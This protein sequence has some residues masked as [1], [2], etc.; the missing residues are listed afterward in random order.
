MDSITQAALGAAVGEAILGKKLGNKGA[1]IGA[2]IATIPDLDILLFPFFNSLQRISL[3]RGY[4]HSIIFCLL[5]AFFLAFLLKQIDWK[6]KVSYRKFWL[7]SF[8]ALITHVLLDAF[9]SYGTQLFLPINNWR[10]SFD[11]ISIID[12]VYTVLLV[13]G[14]LSSTILFKKEDK[15][16]GFPNNIGLIFSTLYLLFTLANK[17][18]IEDVFYSQLEEK[19]IPSFHLLTV[20]VAIGSTSWYG[21]AKDKTHLHIGRYSLIERNEIDFHS[22]PINEQLLENLDPELVNKLKWFAQGFYT[23]AEKDGKIRVYNMQCDMQGV[24]EFGDYKAPTAFYYEIHPK[25][26]GSYELNSG[27]HNSE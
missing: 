10:V 26:D 14:V 7:F 24:R 1:I 12:P 18:H 3:H 13:I 25:G 8:M 27:M 19:N 5:L 9:T 20:P 23:V 6:E 11:S 22:F 15:R 16:R 2:V 21:V 17:Q 4:S